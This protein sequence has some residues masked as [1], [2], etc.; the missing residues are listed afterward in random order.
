[1]DIVSYRMPSADPVLNF[2]WTVR[3]HKILAQDHPCLAAI[4]RGDLGYLQHELSRKRLQLSHCTTGGYSLLHV[5]ISHMNY[6][7]VRLMLV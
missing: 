1:V 4:E 6:D 5:S 7:S 2:R 3:F